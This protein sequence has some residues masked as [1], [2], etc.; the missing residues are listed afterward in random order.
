ME[1]VTKFVLFFFSS[2]KTTRR[3][4]SVSIQ[5]SIYSQIF[6]LILSCI[7]ANIHFTCKIISMDF[8]IRQEKAQ[9]SFPLNNLCPF[10]IFQSPCSSLEKNNNKNYSNIENYLERFKRSKIDRTFRERI[11]KTPIL[12][13]LPADA[14]LII[15]SS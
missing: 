8:G 9:I 5:A 1:S 14:S 11:S 6:T 4:A 3:H 10:S 2:L 13:S 12:S 7:H 15:H